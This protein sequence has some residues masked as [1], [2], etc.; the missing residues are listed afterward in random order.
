VRRIF[1]AI[2]GEENP[3]KLG[4]A[5][6]SLHAITCGALASLISHGWRH[7]RSGH[8][9]LG[10]E[11]GVDACVGVEGACPGGAKI[12]NLAGSDT[13]ANLFWRGHALR[14]VSGKGF[15]DLAHS[16]LGDKA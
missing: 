1:E 6:R 15:S 9:L 7:E 13:C 12:I 16:E 10:R 4:G 5:R 14:G 2:Q 3:R 11:S 8:G